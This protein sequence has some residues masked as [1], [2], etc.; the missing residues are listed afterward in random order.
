M[1]SDSLIHA[2]VATNAH[3]ATKYHSEK[4]VSKAT[5]VLYRHGKTPRFSR[6]AFE[7]VLTM[8]KPNFAERAFIKKCKKAGETFPVKKIQLKFPPKARA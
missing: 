8:G 6:R 3:T 4:L 7:F 2:L 1:K 5:R